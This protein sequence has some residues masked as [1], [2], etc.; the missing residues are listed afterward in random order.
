MY[1]QYATDEM[2]GA[3]SRTMHKGEQVGDEAW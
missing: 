3:D 1:W 2:P